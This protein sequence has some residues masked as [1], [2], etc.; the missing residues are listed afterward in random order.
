MFP[1]PENVPTAWRTWGVRY[2]SV[3]TPSPGKE[4]SDP[5]L[6]TPVNAF[7]PSPPGHDMPAAAAALARSVSSSVG[8]GRRDPTRKDVSCILD[9]PGGVCI[10][11]G[12]WR[13]VTGDGWSSWCFLWMFG[14]YPSCSEQLPTAHVYSYCSHC[15]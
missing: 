14:L 6:H 1:K 2:H 12:L 7:L 10:D 9:P 5:S 3:S 11:T 15:S 4:Q 8:G 13:R